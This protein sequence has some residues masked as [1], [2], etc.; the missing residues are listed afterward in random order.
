MINYHSESGPNSGGRSN[1][2]RA[3]DARQRHPCRDLTKTVNK[4]LPHIRY[5]YQ[6]RKDIEYKVE[7]V[8]KLLRTNPA[9]VQI[10]LDRPVIPQRHLNE[11]LMI[12]H[13]DVLSPCGTLPSPDKTQAPRTGP[14]AGRRKRSRTDAP[15]QR[16]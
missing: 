9:A 10:L 4:V 6:D 8:R 12:V 1:E 5:E 14:R 11:L 7:V 16:L 13:P 2:G 15:P 3:N